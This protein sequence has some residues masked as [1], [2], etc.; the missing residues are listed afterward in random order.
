MFFGSKLAGR[1]S[2]SSRQSSKAFSIIV[3]SSTTTT[4]KA[5]VCTH[6]LLLCMWPH[7]LYYWYLEEQKWKPEREGNFEAL[8][9]REDNKLICLLLGTFDSTLKRI[10]S[11][12]S[13]VKRL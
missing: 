1:P 6:S 11:V 12:E 7:F 2:K 9:I 8:Q 13:K 3:L 4:K 10:Q 5:H